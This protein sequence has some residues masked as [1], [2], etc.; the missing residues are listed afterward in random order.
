[1]ATA[2][3][4]RLVFITA[5]S[6]LYYGIVKSASAFV[7]NGPWSAYAAARYRVH[8]PRHDP[9]GSSASWIRRGRTRLT[10]RDAPDPTPL[11]AGR[12]LAQR[13]D[14]RSAIAPGRYLLRAAVF[15]QVACYPIL[16]VIPHQDRLQV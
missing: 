16:D 15:G 9:H 11:P 10:G 3:R 7:P 14:V 4:N 2:A 6:I 1:M 5:L 12:V 8:Q 13:G